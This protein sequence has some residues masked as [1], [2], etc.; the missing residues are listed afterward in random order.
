MEGKDKKR[1]RGG[2]ADRRKQKAK[3]RRK[4]EEGG[5][6][7]YELRSYKLE[8]PFFEFYYSRQLASLFPSQEE[9]SAFVAAMK[10]PLP[11]TFRVNP[12]F[13]NYAHIVSQLKDPEFLANHGYV[14]LLE[15]APETDPAPSL[16]PIAFYPEDLVFE[17]S[18]TRDLLKKNPS[19]KSVHK[20]I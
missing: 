17:M 15:G 8:S 11:I 19:L 13:N 9:F 1:K 7:E 4:N 20:Y 10:E 12:L 18:I 14:P 6:T 2:W 3:K 16:R 5:N